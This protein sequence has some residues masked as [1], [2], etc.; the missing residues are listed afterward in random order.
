MQLRQFMNFIC[1]SFNPTIML[2]SL[3]SPS[4]RTCHSHALTAW[5][6]LVRNQAV[7]DTFARWQH[8]TLNPLQLLVL[9]LHV[10]MSVLMVMLMLGQVVMRRRCACVA[11]SVDVCRTLTSREQVFFSVI[12]QHR[13]RCCEYISDVNALWNIFNAKINMRVTVTIDDRWV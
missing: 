1:I 8:R 12:R 3:L 6:V 11:T 9:L 5:I 4:V 10:M 13:A 2:H 7:C